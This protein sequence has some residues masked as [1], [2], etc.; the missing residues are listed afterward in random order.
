MEVL[1]FEQ[2]LANISI[3]E[4]ERHDTGQWY[5][6]ITVAELTEAVPEIDWV[7]YLETLMPGVFNEALSYR[8]WIHLELQTA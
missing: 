3:D 5:T 6:K 2:T 8:F 1:Q 7:L 4:A